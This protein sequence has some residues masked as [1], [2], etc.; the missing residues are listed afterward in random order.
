MLKGQIVFVLQSEEIEI[1]QSMYDKDFLIE[2]ETPTFSIMVHVG[3]KEGEE[4]TLVV[5]YNLDYPAHSPP[6]YH[7]SV[8]W[9]GEEQRRRICAGLEEIYL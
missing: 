7:L 6:I 8:P 9:L 4:A 2:D 5:S 1:L 3:E